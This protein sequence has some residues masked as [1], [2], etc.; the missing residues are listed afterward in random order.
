MLE[1]RA[2]PRS[3]GEN[4]KVATSA[5]E[6][7]GSSPLTRGK[8]SSS[9][10]PLGMPGLIPAHA[11]KTHTEALPGDKTRAHPRSRGENFTDSCTPRPRGGSSPLT[12]GKQTTSRKAHHENGLIPAH[13]GKTPWGGGRGWPGGAHP[14]SRGENHCRQRVHGGRRGSSPLTR[15]KRPRQTIERFQD[16][17]IPAHA[18]KT[19]DRKRPCRAS[20]AHP[21]SRG[22]NQVR[23]GR[24]GRLSGSSPLTRGKP[25]ARDVLGAALGLIPAHAGKTTPRLRGSCRD[26]AHPRSRGENM[27]PANS[28][29]IKPGSSPL[30]R[31][32]PTSPP[33]T[34]IPR[35]LIPAHAGKTCATVSKS[36][37]SQA[38]PRSRGENSASLRV[39][40]SVSG[41]SPLTRGKRG[42]L[43]RSL[44]GPGLIPAHAGKTAQQTRA[45][46]A[47]QAHPRS[48][49]ENPVSRRRCADA[50]G[51]SPLT[52][53]KP[54]DY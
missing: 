39:A 49:G 33:R 22:E 6:V 32:K 5:T 44:S 23:A 20:Q 1:P 45:T 9:T 12:R 38:H 47:G 43:F 51:S 30:T 28:G 26:W 31:G 54:H 8:L 7:Q 3:R 53:G 42:V 34:P 19:R 41:S 13:A 4:G 37:A 15:G 40:P 21:R 2:H 46:P 50:Q 11:G 10:T 48:R 18:G 17:L 35:R 16:G 36:S 27:G 52:R 24:D 25:V 29:L 14:R